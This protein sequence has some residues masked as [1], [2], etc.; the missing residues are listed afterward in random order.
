MKK[1]IEY[2][3]PYELKKDKSCKIS[4]PMRI[5]PDVK[6]Q[7]AINLWNN[8]MRR[9]YKEEGDSNVTLI[10]YPNTASSTLAK[11]I[12]EFMHDENHIFLAFGK[13]KLH[14][15]EVYEAARLGHSTWGRIMNGETLDVER[16]NVFAIALA[17][18]LND[19]QTVKL[20]QSAGLCLNYEIELDAAIMYFIKKGDYVVDEVWRILEQFTN[21]ENG[22][23]CF[24]FRK[25]KEKKPC[26]RRKSF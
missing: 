14:A 26:K 5:K 9:V 25:D 3:D 24:T 12:Y 7:D 13:D 2:Y 1:Q 4:Q 8:V 18:R 17:L 15:K 16:A 22:L 21:L 6:D 20:L 23:D 10:D 11:T 19:E